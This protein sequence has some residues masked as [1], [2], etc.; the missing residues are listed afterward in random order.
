MN[1]QSIFSKE[2]LYALQQLFNKIG[3][4]AIIDH[5]GYKCASHSEYKKI[6][7]LFMSQQQQYGIWAYES[8]ISNRKIT[9]VRL[10]HP[11][12]LNTKH[13]K[14]EINYLEIQDQKP[15]SS[16]VSGIDHIEI[17]PKEKVTQELLIEELRLFQY[18]VI[19]GGKAHHVTYD[20]EIPYLNNKNLLVKIPKEPLVE[21]IKRDEMK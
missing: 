17:L 13:G 2:L 9:Y 1:I 18:N 3:D 14:I 7:G 6:R 8:Y 21:K 16:Q 11:I 15:D 10:K 4:R 20:F 19:L 12:V 5:A